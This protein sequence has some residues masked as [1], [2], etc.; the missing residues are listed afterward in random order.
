[1]S[2]NTYRKFRS[3]EY[4]IPIYIYTRTAAL[5]PTRKTLLSI[6][7]FY[8]KKREEAARGISNRR[9]Y[10]NTLTA[11]LR[12]FPQDL[13]PAFNVTRTTRSGLFILTHTRVHF[14]SRQCGTGRSSLSLPRIFC[15]D[16][17]CG[18]K[19]ARLR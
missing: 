1:M 6:E 5:S 16:Q 14:P 19:I 12:I 15:T 7:D 11:R 17:Q 18:G 3:T 4:S 13:S 8:Y 2:A 10:I 9:I